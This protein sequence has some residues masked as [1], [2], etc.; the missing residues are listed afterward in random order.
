MPVKW[1]SFDEDTPREAAESLIDM[2]LDIP[3]E[4]VDRFIDWLGAELALA[5]PESHHSYL[6][7]STSLLLQYAMTGHLWV[8]GNDHK[9]FFINSPN[10]GKTLWDGDLTTLPEALTKLNAARAAGSGPH[11]ITTDHFAP[12]CFD[13]KHWDDREKDKAP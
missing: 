1:D 9:R 12:V 6:L 11:Y 3:R 7:L 2:Q 13:W 4:A 10:S 8:M 5:P